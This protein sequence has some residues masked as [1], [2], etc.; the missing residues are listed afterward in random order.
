VI[1]VETYL[2]ERAVFGQAMDM[3]ENRRLQ[4]QQAQGGNAAPG[5]RVPDAPPAPPEGAEPEAPVAE[6]K[7][8]ATITPEGVSK[9]AAKGPTAS[10]MTEAV[11]KSINTIGV[12]KTRDI[13]LSFGHGQVMK[14]EPEKW[15]DVLVALAA[16]AK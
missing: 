5:Q 11:N 9:P 15:P 13:L 3:I 1:K 2:F 6:E 16:A 14:I 10:Q 8:V 7:I 4:I 12:P